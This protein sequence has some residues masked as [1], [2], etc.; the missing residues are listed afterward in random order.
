MSNSF[1]EQYTSQVDI[2]KRA[3]AKAISNIYEDVNTIKIICEATQSKFFSTSNCILLFTVKHNIFYECWYFAED[4]AALETAFHLF[5]KD[6]A[7]T[8]PIRFMIVGKDEQTKHICNMLN[9]NGCT[10]KA[11]LA[12]NLATIEASTIKM[13][14]KEHI[15]DIIEFATPDDVQEIFD[16]LNEEFDLY[17][18]NLPELQEIKENIN[19]QQIVII[20]KNNK[21][22]LLNYFTVKNNIMHGYYD[23]VRK[24]FRNGQLYFS[25]LIFI[26]NYIKNNN[27]K[28]KYE[29]RNITKKR[30]AKSP[31]VAIN[32]K[33]TIYI[34]FYVY[35]VQNNMDVFQC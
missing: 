3:N 18:D 34:N 10:L 30:L 13:L 23:L 1:F 26:F 24:E 33:Y 17:A 2:I 35:N 5:I 22:A 19:K 28:R 8:L 15:A 29:W 20:R 25:F 9:N 16:M 27:I 21:I 6:Y 32:E 11:K 31:T 7:E 12:R 14:Q 4:I